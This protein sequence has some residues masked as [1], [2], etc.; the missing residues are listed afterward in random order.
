MAAAISPVSSDYELIFGVPQGSVLAP[1]FYYVHE[2]YEQ[3][4]PI[5]TLENTAASLIMRTM[6]Q[7]HIT[8]TLISL[9]W[10]PVEFQSQYN[11]IITV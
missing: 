8:P 3:W 9:H 4:H 2:N 7:D 5:K 1:K 10:L 6:K 11:I